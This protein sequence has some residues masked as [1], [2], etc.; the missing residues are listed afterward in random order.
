MNEGQFSS[1]NN[2]LFISQKSSAMGINALLREIPLSVLLNS[3]SIKINFA[4]TRAR[5]ENR[6]CERTTS[7]SLIE[8]NGLSIVLASNK[9]GWL[10]TFLSCMTIFMS[11]KKSFCFILDLVSSLLMNS[12]YRYRCLL[13]NGHLIMYSVFVG[14]CFSTSFFIRRSKKGRKIEWSFVKIS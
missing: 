8:I 2:I 9:S 6:K 10:Q 12:S 11:P 1:E 3:L 5:V 14:S 7:L 4:G 13:D